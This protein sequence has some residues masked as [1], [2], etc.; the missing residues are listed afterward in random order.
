MTSASSVPV[1]SR[2]YRN[3]RDIIVYVSGPITAEE[4]YQ[5][6]DNIQKARMIARRLWSE[7]YTVICPQMNTA[8]MD[9]IPGM[10]HKD[11]LRGDIQIL[12]RAIDIAVFIPGWED[13]KGCEE[14]LQFC[15]AIGLP[16]FYI[17]RDLEFSMEA[18]RG[19]TE[20]ILRGQYK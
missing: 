6:E 20:N 17:T 2:H 18:L 7:G 5:R 14:E 12:E 3:R 19:W 4:P 11:W 8:F 10:D 15:H 9:G 13:S 16:T 1:T